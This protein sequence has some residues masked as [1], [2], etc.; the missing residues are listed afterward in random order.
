MLSMHSGY[1][2]HQLFRPEPAVPKDSEGPLYLYIGGDGQPWRTPKEI[3]R[4]P[5]SKH[6]VLLKSMLLAEP[7]SI[8]V[9]RPCYYQVTDG[10]CSGRWWTRDRYHSDV[11]NSV[12]KVVEQLSKKHKELWLIGYSGGGTL[13]VLVGRRLNR[14]VNVVTINA[15]LNHQ[16]WT[17]HHR[18]SPLAGSLNPIQDSARNPD[19]QELHWYG[20]ADQN[21]LSEWILAYCRATQTLCVPFSGDHTGWV[22]RWPSM[23]HFSRCAFSQ[24]SSEAKG[25]PN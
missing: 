9:G 1:F 19:M 11:V 15:N 23:L 3:A 8:Y 18:Y 13:A 6:S 2:E 5:T 20:T 4:N 14:P 24:H 25:C 22:A 10:R 7:E 12:L 16:A 21:I 17:D